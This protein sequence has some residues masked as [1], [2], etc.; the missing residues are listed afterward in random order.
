MRL[1]GSF[2]SSRKPIVEGSVSVE[3][4]ELSRRSRVKNTRENITPDHR[5]R[6]YRITDSITG[7]VT[8]QP[9]ELT[10]GDLLPVD[11]VVD[12]LGGTALLVSVVDSVGGLTMESDGNMRSSREKSSPERRASPRRFVKEFILRRAEKAL[13]SEVLL[14]KAN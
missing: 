12:V 13:L 10:K 7:W 5:P 1:F 9:R 2:Q 8:D 4:R 11:D 14:R 3:G 6:I